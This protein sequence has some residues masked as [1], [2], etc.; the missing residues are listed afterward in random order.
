MLHPDVYLYPKLNT[1]KKITQDYTDPYG[2]WEVRTEGDVEGH[3]TKYLGTFTGFV[4]EIA[5]HLADKCYYSLRF[6]KV[7][8][9]KEFKPTRD[10]VHVSF[11][12]TSNTWDLPPLGRVEAVKE[13]F[14]NR[15]VSINVGQFYASF[16]ISSVMTDEDKLEMKRQKVLKKLSPEERELLGFK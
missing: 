5:L 1:M 4:D 3:S 11:D 13:V 14:K 15:P 8:P 10:S 7:E 2:T 16:L 9:I 6:T 12:I